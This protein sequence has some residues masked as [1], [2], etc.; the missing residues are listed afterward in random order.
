MARG[1]VTINSSKVLTGIAIIAIIL[2][3]PLTCPSAKAQTSTTFSPADKFSI[4][5]Y[6]G[7]FNFAVN[8][9]YSKATFENN[10]W[11]FENLRLN[12]S[13][14]LENFKLSTQNSN[15]TIVSYRATN[16]TF[17]SVR[18]RYTVE[19]KGKQ[20]LNLGISPGQRGLS[21]SVYWTVSVNNRVWAEGT[22]WSIS[23]NGTITVKDA[24]GNVSIA[25]S[26]FSG[27]FGNGIPN[28]NLPFYQ[29]HSIA[30]TVAIAVAATVAV[31]VA[32]KVTS[33]KHSVESESVKNA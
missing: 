2:I 31:A 9:T 17:E 20:V 25:Y 11:A 15:L 30:I 18:L 22:G 13:Q 6:N 21:P 5:A 4:P 8:G 14:P 19:G 26:N 16:I 24:S 23:N 7:S 29:Q 10:N 32:I 27:N 3:L 1:S 28:S 33:R 12:G